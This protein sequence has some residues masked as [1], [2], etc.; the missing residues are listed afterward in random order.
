MV[1][2][3]CKALSPEESVKKILAESKVLLLIKGSLESPQDEN[4]KAMIAKI[5]ALKCEFT[6]IDVVQNA[7]YLEYLPKEIEIPYLFL[8]GKAA[9]GLSGI[10]SIGDTPEFK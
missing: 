10:D 8:S 5:Y 3:Q 9:C 7:A 2:Q 4:S 1:P 6:A